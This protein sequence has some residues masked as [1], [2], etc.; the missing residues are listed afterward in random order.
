[1]KWIS[2]VN[3]ANV[4]IPFL[5]IPLFLSQNNSSASFT[6]IQCSG[7]V[8]FVASLHN[9]CCCGCWVV[10]LLQPLYYIYTCVTYVLGLTGGARWKGEVL[11]CQRCRRRL[12]LHVIFGKKGVCKR[13]RNVQKYMMMCSAGSLSFLFFFFFGDGE[14]VDV[15]LTAASKH[16]DWNFELGA[17]FKSTDDTKTK[18]NEAKKRQNERKNRTN[19]TPRSAVTQPKTHNK[20][21]ESEG[22]GFRSSGLHTVGSV[23]AT[24]EMVVA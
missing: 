1:M 6:P 16:Q 11:C 12:D 22:C 19:N 14:G 21:E 17:R 9:V 5:S 8:C 23:V 24:G 15:G 20:E 18:Q 7:I 2:G 3:Y 4:P 10:A 13:R